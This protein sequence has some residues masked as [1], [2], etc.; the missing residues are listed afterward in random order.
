MQ[1]SDEIDPAT[2]NTW[3]LGM[4]ALANALSILP[5]IKVFYLPPGTVYDKTGPPLVCMFIAAGALLLG[6]CISV[7][8]FKQRK[9]A[10]ALVCAVFS[11]TPL[12]AG[13]GTAYA[14]GSWRGIAIP[15]LGVK[16]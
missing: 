13:L 4:P 16:P 10:R 9:V 6:L 12:L 14:V 7:A 1:D 11:L 15:L 5:W 2:L 3:W 8:L